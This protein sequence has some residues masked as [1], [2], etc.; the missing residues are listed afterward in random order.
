MSFFWHEG[1]NIA[2][3]HAF[4]RN[5]ET[6]A[7]RVAIRLRN[8]RRNFHAYENY[9]DAVLRQATFQYGF[10]DEIRYCDD[11]AGCA[12]ARHGNGIRRQR[13][14]YAAR[15]NQGDEAMRPRQPCGGERVRLIG[16]DD[17]HSAA[18]HQPAD[19]Q[20]GSKAPA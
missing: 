18:S 2:E 5:D 9:F 12:I 17:I 6:F 4:G 11:A 8:R 15:D 20:K 16:M 10:F 3:A 14:F 13:E 19:R 7:R 1:R